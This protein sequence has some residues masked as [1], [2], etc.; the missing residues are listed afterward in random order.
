MRTKDSS[1]WLRG[2]SAECWWALHVADEL[3]QEFTG[4]QQLVVTSG[5]EPIEHSVPRSA[6]HR[7]DAA[8]L[9]TWY[10]GS[11]VGD[12]AAEL[13]RRVGPHY[14]VVVERSPP[15]IHMHWSPER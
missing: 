1:V 8:D 2:L 12:F 15:H 5:C 14:V 3:H 9:R 13:Q 11:R 6:H 10:L 7:G 4:G